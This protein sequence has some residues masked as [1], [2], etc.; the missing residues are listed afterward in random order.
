MESRE[1]AE[2]Q[3][4]SQESAQQVATLKQEVATKTAEQVKTEFLEAFSKAEEIR[5]IV[6]TT[7]EREQTAT[8]RLL[9]RKEDKTT[10][11][12]KATDVKE[13]VQ[14]ILLSAK[15]P[16]KIPPPSGSPTPEKTRFTSNLITKISDKIDP[17]RVEISEQ[18]A[19]YIYQIL[20]KAINGELE[21]VEDLVREFNRIEVMRVVS[22]G[23]YRAFQDAMVE[24]AMSYNYSELNAKE[25]FGVVEDKTVKFN[26]R[27][28]EV[29]HSQVAFEP[30][31]VKELDRLSYI[32]HQS[33]LSH[34]EKQ[35]L[36]DSLRSGIMSPDVK[37]KLARAGLT[38][39]QIRE[40][41][42]LTYKAAKYKEF[43]GSGYGDLDHYFPE[44]ERRKFTLEYLKAHKF[45]DKDGN[46]HDY[47]SEHGL[48]EY[49]KTM[50]RRSALR[51]VNKLFVKADA[52][53]GAEFEKNFSEFHEGYIFRDIQ[54][55]I[56]NLLEDP[57]LVTLFGGIHS[58]EYRNTVYWIKEGVLNEIGREK[59]LRS[60]YHNVGIWI[61][62]M[63]P[64]QLSE[65]MA[66]HNVSESTSALLSD[67]SGKL[68]SLAMSEYERYIQYDIGKN[69]GKVRPGLFSGKVNPNELYY[70]EQDVTNFRENFMSTVKGLERYAETLSDDARKSIESHDLTRYDLD[71][72]EGIEQW[73]IDRALK[74]ARGIHLTQTIRGYELVASTRAPETFFGSADNF[75]DMAA[76]LNPSWRWTLGRG[77][78]GPNAGIR[79]GHVKEIMTSDMLVRT[80]Q[81]SLL[82][83]IFDGSWNPSKLHHEAEKYSE[84]KLS[85]N[86]EKIKD[87]WL[88]KDMSFRQLINKFSST[89]GLYGRGG[90]RKEG[91]QGGAFDQYVKGVEEAIRKTVVEGRTFSKDF[92]FGQPGHWDETYRALSQVVGV[93]TRFWF[94]GSRAEAYVKAAL[95][96]KLGI[97]P[98]K[99]SSS[100]LLEIWTDYTDGGYGDRTIMTTEDGTK[101]TV[102]DL[103]EARM[104]V[105]E[106]MNFYDLLKRSPIDFLNNLL[107]LQPQLLTKGLG[108]ESDDILFEYFAGTDDDPRLIKESELRERL[109][110]KFSGQKLHDN[111]E[112]IL[113]F[114]RTL[115]KVWGE[116]NFV[117]IKFVRN[118]YKQLEEVAA[119]KGMNKDK[120]LS[121][122]Y[123]QMDLATEKVKLRKSEEMDPSDI[124][125]AD[126]REM[127]FGDKGLI[128]HFKNIDSIKNKTEFG[129]DVDKLGERG[130]FYYM[131]R[132]WY[133]ELGTNIHPNT[134][135]VDW[136][137]ILHNIGEMTGETLVRRLWG[138]MAGWN[139]IMSGLMNIDHML[140]DAAVSHSLDKIVEFQQKISDGLEGISGKSA[141]YETQFYFSQLVARYFQEHAA[142]RLPF[143]VGAIYSAFNGGTL[144]LSRIYNGKGAMTLTTD[145]I[146]S[147]FQRLRNMLILAPNGQFGFDR[148]TKSVGADWDKLFLSETLPNIASLL[149]LFLFWRAIS[150]ALKATEGKKK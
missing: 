72:L 146:N 86:W 102:K 15:T 126:L 21:S 109:K 131:A 84:F 56:V 51:A 19:P 46:S 117:H 139:E 49:G 136:R 114:Q 29:E 69:N 65:H 133:N 122:F 31:E 137:F 30:N 150:E 99:L 113:Y 106:G 111:V 142:S 116:K 66:Q 24:V 6:E 112:K 18:A 145:G 89:S 67:V 37:D 115:K 54:E 119:R 32:I 79:M 88:Y 58:E 61:K 28:R 110:S 130:F 132:G 97:D 36:F 121:F 127:F 91:F 10:A 11:L 78:G 41:G 40:M 44:E 35:D 57:N 2:P 59:E 98:D 129:N 64:K 87:S 125:D 82:K 26:P 92:K 118:F 103:M 90:W 53:P 33:N 25:K 95:W 62:M 48:T 77:G 149:M 75:Y 108:G 47:I 104:T 42:N 71:N 50:L 9:G 22:P 134:A 73:E 63:Q 16:D 140:R 135:D 55:T 123:K 147:Y 52:Q 107:N 38:E 13:A 94:D 144:S 81:E 141:M 74:Y 1:R 143:P 7:V 96:K 8:V 148:L 85:E 45:I 23:L 39:D 43:K 80:P 70:D 34:E 60:L 27:T 20:N 128:T 5:R 105:L 14:K 124:E 4:L 12:G 17:E 83:R 138:D 76:N 68:I 3:A 100:K 101:M 120:F 93:G